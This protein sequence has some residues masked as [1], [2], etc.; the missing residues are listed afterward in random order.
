MLPEHDPLDDD[1]ALDD[2]DWDAVEAEYQQFITEA[3]DGR[4]PTLAELVR[5]ITLMRR[6]LRQRPEA[7]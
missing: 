4:L 1:D 7:N 3:Y 5:D 6:Q 2:V